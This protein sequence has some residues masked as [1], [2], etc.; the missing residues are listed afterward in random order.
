M[1]PEFSCKVE[2]QF[3]RCVLGDLDAAA[4]GIDRPFFRQADDDGLR[5]WL[6]GVLMLDLSTRNLLKHR[7]V[8]RCVST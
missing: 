8:L 2:L 7:V 1:E 4:E 6:G 3:H 5:R